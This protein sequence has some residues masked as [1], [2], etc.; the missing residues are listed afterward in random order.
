MLDADSYFSNANH[1]GITFV[2]ILFISVMLIVVADAKFVR[3]LDEN[4]ARTNAEETEQS[5]SVTEIAPKHPSDFSIEQ[6]QLNTVVSRQIQ[7][8]LKEAIAINSFDFKDTDPASG[9][10][11]FV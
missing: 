6:A 8:L 11:I 4:A 5:A 10:R 9:N 2:H 3:N 1:N 7:E